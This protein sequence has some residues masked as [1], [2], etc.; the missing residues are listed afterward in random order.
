[1][2]ADREMSS[3]SNDEMRE[4]MAE[5]ANATAP[6]INQPEISQPTEISSGL[7]IGGI[8]SEDFNINTETPIPSYYEHKCGRGQRYDEACERCHRVTVVCNDCGRC[9]RCHDK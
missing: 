2:N 7:G 3:F 8:G 6:E 1:M 5:C 9:E 4:L